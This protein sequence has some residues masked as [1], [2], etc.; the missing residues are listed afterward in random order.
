ML[1][2]FTVNYV[3]QKTKQKH[4]NNTSVF[5]LH[6][7]ICMQLPVRID[8]ILHREEQMMDAVKKNPNIQN[9]TKRIIKG[10]CSNIELGLCRGGEFY[11]WRGP[12]HLN[13]VIIN[14]KVVLLPRPQVTLDNFAYSVQTP[15]F[16]CFQISFLSNILVLSV[17]DEG[18]SSNATNISEILF[19]SS[20]ISNQSLKQKCFHQLLLLLLVIMTFQ[21]C[22]MNASFFFGWLYC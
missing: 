8:T 2:F 9:N 20:F 15:W 13:N 18:H 11:C 16:L 14:R 1:I 5:P 6:D 21:A 10:Y 4:L 3:V 22:P 19:T 17:P 12:D 7:F